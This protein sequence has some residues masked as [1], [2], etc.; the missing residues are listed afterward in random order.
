MAIH[1]L[2]L[3]LTD[4]D[5]AALAISVGSVENP[6]TNKQYATAYDLAMGSVSYYGIRPGSS[7]LTAVGL[8]KAAAASAQYDL[9]VAQAPVVEGWLDFQVTSTTPS[10]I[11]AGSSGTC[12]VTTTL[13]SG[14]S[15]TIT[16]SYLEVLPLPDAVIRGF[17]AAFSPTTI[18]SSGATSTATISVPGATPAGSYTIAL[19]GKDSNNVDNR[20]LVN[21]TV[22]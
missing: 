1:Y 21:F 13:D 14:Y 10:A 11:T 19:I 6:V 9:L 8:A 3:A 2:H 22:T 16:F 4:D 17:T 20:A 12:T 18:N 15:D 7:G 5:T